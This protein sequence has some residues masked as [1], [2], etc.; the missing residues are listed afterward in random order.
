MTG[1]DAKDGRLGFTKPLHYRC[2]N[3]ASTLAYSRPTASPEAIRI[4]LAT[5]N[6]VRPPMPLG[7]SV[8]HPLR[9]WQTRLIRWGALDFAGTNHADHVSSRPSMLRGHKELRP[10]H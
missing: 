10:Q 5:S 9:P 2:A 4:C 1:I 7:A 3:P 8:A 6:V